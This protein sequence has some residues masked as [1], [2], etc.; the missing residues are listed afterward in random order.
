MTNRDPNGEHWT[1]GTLRLYLE[2]L[3]EGLKDTVTSLSDRVNDRF[4]AI[5]K[6][7]NVAIASADRATTKAEVSADERFKGVNEFRQTLSDQARDL[8][9]R[10]ES[11]ANYKSLRE[12]VEKLESKK[13][14]DA[15][16]TTGIKDSL[17]II[18]AVI[19]LIAT[20]IMGAFY[21][22][23]FSGKP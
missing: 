18:V 2:A 19:S 6:A 13:D 10:L 15:G 3:I 11:E 8:M 1:L 22:T 17:A 14:L 20:V 21:A 23:H 7:V 5:E 16:H 4:V 9:P 12:R